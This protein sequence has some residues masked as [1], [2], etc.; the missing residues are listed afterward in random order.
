MKAVPFNKIQQKPYWSRAM[1]RLISFLKQT[2]LSRAVTVFLASAL[3]IFSTACSGGANA[4][5]A[6]T[7]RLGVSDE[8][9][10]NARTG[11]QTELYD[12]TQPRQGGMNE[13]SDVDKR[14]DASKA[15]V[16]A[17]QLVDNAERNVSDRN[18]ELGTSTKRA[19][20]EKGKD[21]RDFGS[22]LKEKANELGRQTRQTVGA[23]RQGTRQAGE[24]LN[25][26]ASRAADRASDSIQNRADE[27]ADRTQQ[28]LEKSGKAI[29]RTLDKAGDAVDRN[30]AELDRNVRSAADSTSNFLKD[31]ANEAIGTAQQNLDKAQDKINK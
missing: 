14:V 2:S 9:K 30:R 23:A 26:N 4:G 8:G 11:Y 16:K 6:G 24:D 18:S 17:R 5:V 19:L 10:T 1:I 12:Q 20:E 15:S 25:K 3:L 29:D 22:E 31:R 7:D 27:A 13:F 28:T 21:M